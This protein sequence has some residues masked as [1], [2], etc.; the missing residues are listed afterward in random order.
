[1]QFP[2]AP[3]SPP[4]AADQEFDEWRHWFE[5][6][7][8]GAALDAAVTTEADAA[9]VIQRADMIA[10]RAVQLIKVRAQAVRGKLR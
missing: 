10:T 6:A 5:V 2:G 8:S 1:M 3:S 7:L 4:A 9:K